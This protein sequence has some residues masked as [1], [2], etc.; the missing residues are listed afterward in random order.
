MFALLLAHYVIAYDPQLPPPKQRGQEASLTTETT[1]SGRMS[2]SADLSIERS[3]MSSG[4]GRD[5]WEP[6]SVDSKLLAWVR[7]HT[8]AILT[9]C[10][11]SNYVAKVCGSTCIQRCFD[12][13]SRQ[14]SP[15][16]REYWRL[17]QVITVRYQYVRC[18]A[19]NR[20]K[21]PCRRVSLP[22]RGTFSNPLANNYLP[23]LVLQRHTLDWADN[24]EEI[25]ATT[26]SG[27]VRTGGTNA[28][29][30]THPHSSYDTNHF[31]QLAVTP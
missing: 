23:C 1:Q 28:H 16:A 12:K 13:V 10:R 3:D 7:S 24:S 14:L 2:H 29:P 17:R 4:T 20:H 31:L 9:F 18:S 8:T 15:F 22:E 11:L 26:P 19:R 5:Y 6:N 30:A 27:E 25:P 21:H